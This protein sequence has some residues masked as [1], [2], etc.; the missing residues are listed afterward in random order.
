MILY[1]AVTS[2]KAYPGIS[3][4]AS[5]TFMWWYMYIPLCLLTLLWIFYTAYPGISYAICIT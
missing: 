2:H 3:Y 4:M 5:I 1:K